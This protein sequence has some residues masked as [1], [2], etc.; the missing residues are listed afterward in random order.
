MRDYACIGHTVA[1]S[2]VVARAGLSLVY[3]RFAARGCARR[4]ILRRTSADR[5]RRTFWTLTGWEDER[6]MKAFRGAGAHARVMPRLFEW[7]DEAA[8]THWTAPDSEIPDWLQAHEHLSSE[9]RLSRVA[10]PSADHGERQL[11]RQP[12]L[13]PLD[14]TKP[15]SCSGQKSCGLSRTPKPRRNPVSAAITLSVRPRP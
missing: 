12:R 5:R 2:S 14:W 7:C 11:L 10:H 8:Y 9:G 1:S 4:R 6:A 15:K 13:Q 3:L